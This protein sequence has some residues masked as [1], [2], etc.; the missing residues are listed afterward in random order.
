M[1]KV[2]AALVNTLYLKAVWENKFQE[3]VSD[4]FTTFDGSE[5]TKDFMYAT[6][7]YRYYEGSDGK[8]VVIPLKGGVDAIFT[9]GDIDDIHDAYKQSHFEQVHV[10]IP[11]Y[12]AE[13]SFDNKEFIGFLK[14]KGVSKAFSAEADFSI[15]CPDAEWNISDIIQKT[16]ITVD[17][18][19]IEAT[20]AT[21]V[22]MLEGALEIEEDPKEFIAN[23]PFKFYIC[24]GIDDSEVLF[25]GQI[26]E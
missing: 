6:D 21:A 3:P 22:M 20:A 15:M 13:S 26:V 18:E 14:S 19:G 2:N 9:L 17:E 1:S 10:G 16:K 5:V 24:T 4:K 7:S 12:E 8:M 25:C 11:K 23:E